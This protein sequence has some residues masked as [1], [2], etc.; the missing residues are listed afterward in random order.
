MTP[1]SFTELIAG[2]VTVILMFDL[3]WVLIVR[4][5]MD[6]RTAVLGLVGTAVGFYLRGR[7]EKEKP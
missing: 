4:G 2:V 7:V 6:T 5:D 1:K 3:S